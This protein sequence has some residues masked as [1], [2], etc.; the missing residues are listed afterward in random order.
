MIKEKE[1]DLFFGSM[2]M[3]D[4]LEMID[5]ASDISIDVPKKGILILMYRLQGKS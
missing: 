3:E 4:V 5:W 2:Y 1:G